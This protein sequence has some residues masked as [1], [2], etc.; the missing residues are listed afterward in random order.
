MVLSDVPLM[1]NGFALSHSLARLGYLVPSDPTRAYAELWE[2]Y[3]AQGYLWLKGLLDRQE[4]LAFRRRYFTAF[5]EAGLP[6]VVPGT[7]PVEGIFDDQAAPVDLGLYHKVLMEIVRW[8][9]YEAFC[10]MTPIRRFYELFLE[11]APY[12]HKRKIIRH[13]KPG[14]PHCTGAHYDL[15]YLRGGTDHICTSWIPI[16]DVPIARGGLVYLEGSDA[17][18]RQKEAE[19]SAL[20]RDLPPEERINAYNRN[21]GKSGWLSKDLAALVDALDTRWLVADYE[22]G[23]MVV[24]SPYMVHASTMNVDPDKRIRLST[25]IRYQRVRDEIDARW[26]NHWSLDDML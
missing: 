19:F 5:I 11:G 16:G 23:D 22:V 24:H 9:E 7:D 26:S 14:D 15:T 25:D 21:M 18:G 1:S 4:V 2:Q 8:A 6:L 3:R 12:L 10:L 17:W 13:G 20:N